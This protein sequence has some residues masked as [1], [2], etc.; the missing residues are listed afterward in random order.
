MKMHF[1]P[2]ILS[3]RRRRILN[4][5]ELVDSLQEIIPTDLLEFSGM[6]FEEQVI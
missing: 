1:V 2:P 3:K 6:T 4:E 5:K